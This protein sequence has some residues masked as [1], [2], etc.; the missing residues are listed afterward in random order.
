MS[1]PIERAQVARRALAQW[2]T[3]HTEVLA[4]TLRGANTRT[5]G[6]D[7]EYE[8]IDLE[9]ALQELPEYHPDEPKGHVIVCRFVCQHEE[10]LGDALLNFD[11]RNHVPLFRAMRQLVTDYM[12]AESDLE[13]GT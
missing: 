13:E 2:T 11:A 8:L 4:N 3:E 10:T 12:E 5:S 7:E 1:T 6:P 9:S